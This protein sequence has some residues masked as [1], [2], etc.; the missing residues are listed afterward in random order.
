MTCEHPVL[1]RMPGDVWWCRKCGH[2][3]TIEADDFHS[4]DRPV[5]GPHEFGAVDDCVRC[6][7][8]EALVG[9]AGPCTAN[10]LTGT[11][12]ES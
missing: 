2:E 11:E 1:D 3:V 6:I 5:Y 9:T 7:W 12:V 4:S 10:V 8:C